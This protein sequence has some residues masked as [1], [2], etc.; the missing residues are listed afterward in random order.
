MYTSIHD[1]FRLTFK[2]NSR[3]PENLHQHVSITNVKFQ[4]YDVDFC[5]QHLPI[6]F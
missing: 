3:D 1:R 4:C 2:L 6:H 5:E